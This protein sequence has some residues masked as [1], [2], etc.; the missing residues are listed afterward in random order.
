MQGDLVAPEVEELEEEEEEGGKNQPRRM[1]PSEVL[2]SM[3]ERVM[4]GDFGGV[5]GCQVD[6]GMLAVS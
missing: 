6:V 5:S 2:N 1:V 4:V 3:S